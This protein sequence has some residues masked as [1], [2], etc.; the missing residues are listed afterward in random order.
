MGRSK[1]RGKNNPPGRRREISKFLG[2]LKAGL[3]IDDI[4]VIEN[5]YDTYT[6][7]HIAQVAAEERAAEY[8]YLQ[9][10]IAD[11]VYVGS[12]YKQKDFNRWRRRN[13]KQFN[14]LMKL[15]ED[16][17][18]NRGNGAAFFKRMRRM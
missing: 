10:I 3:S 16:A 8:V 5:S 11:A 2:L 13:I 7:R 18:K 6:L 12:R 17:K 9:R 4:E 15:E 14:N 1:R